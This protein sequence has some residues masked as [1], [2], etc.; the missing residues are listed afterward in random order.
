[1]AFAKR[2]GLLE[3]HRVL[4]LR[5]NCIRPNPRQPRKLF[6]ADDLHELAESIRLYGVLQPL[7]VRKLENG[8]YELV[9]GERR[10]RASRLAGLDE[11]PCILL[12]AD[13]QQSALI[14]L[15]EN[16]QRCDLDF[17]EEAEG[18]RRLIRQFGLSQEEAAR[19][20]GK[21]QSA[22]ANK[23]RLLRHPQ[24]VVAAIREHG[25]TERH[26]RALL[27]L[28]EA[29]D[30]DAV[31]ET[32]IERRLNVAQTDEYIDA[33]LATAEPAR[34]AVPEVSHARDK[35]RTL[36]VFK[37]IRLFLNTVS[38]ALDVVRRA[39]IPADYDKA[40]VGDEIILT[41]KVPKRV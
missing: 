17:F 29:E 26:A 10:L 6:D 12:G 2:H 3:S 8:A 41:I 15:I 11:V 24:E 22:L 18:I 33:Y 9:A 4:M 13:E 39:G 23:L 21:S 36:Y 32:I 5:A 35:I 37:D 38:H 34:E 1:M 25:L 7:T 16:L 27:R 30:R 19:R 31:M 20:I 28:D 40:E 14:A